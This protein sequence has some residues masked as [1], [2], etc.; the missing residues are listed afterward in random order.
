MENPFILDIDSYKRDIASV[1]QYVEQASMFLHTTTKKDLDI[2]REYVQNTIKNKTLTDIKDPKFTYLE[3][4]DTGDRIKETTTLSKYLQNAIDNE[5]IISAPL[6]TYLPLHVKESYVA[7]YL[8]NNIKLRNIAKKAQFAAEAKGD[9]TLKNIKNSEQTNRKLKNNAVSG[10][11]VSNSTPLFN[12]T[13]HATLTSTCRCTAGYGNSNNEKLMSGNRHYYSPS[14][15]INNITSIITITDLN[16]LQLVIDK[17]NL[18]IPTVDD[19]INCIKKSTDYYWHDKYNLDIITDYIVTLSPVQRAAVVYVGDLYHVMKLNSNF[20]KVFIGEISARDITVIDKPL[21]IIYQIR[22]DYVELAHQIMSKEL[23]GKGKDYRALD[24]KILND[25]TATA[26]HIENTVIKYKDFI[27]AIMVTPNVP[28]SVA[29]FPNS[30]REVALV[31]DTDSTIFTVQ[32][33]VRWYCGDI[34]FTEEADA[35]AATCIFLAS[36]AITHILAMMSANFGVDKSNLFLIAMKNEFKFSVFVPSNVAKHYFASITA[37]EGNIKADTEI[38]IKGVHLKNSN[39]P[40]PIIKAANQLME[41]IL[42]DTQQGKQIS[43]FETL[44]FVADIERYVYDSIKKG[45]VEI[46]KILNIQK[47]EAYKNPEQSNYQR[48]IFWNTTFGTKYSIMPEP[49]YGCIKVSTVLNNKKA[50]TQWLDLMEDKALSDLLRKYIVDNN[51]SNL[52]VLFIPYEVT[53]QFGIPKEI[54][55]IVDSRSIVAD[56]CKIFYIILET[57]GIYILGTKQIKLASDD[58]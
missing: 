57:L 52:D 41:K 4:Q 25:L 31:S 47:A 51:K 3:R 2:C 1:K 38:E 13:A 23:K 35:V 9:I 21:D 8:I 29:N 19:T 18:Y 34:V 15:V 22:E 48:H 26:L 16:K 32:D 45:S 14:V 55:D 56:L 28:A 5:L 12:P 53:T 17:Y 7:R 27:Q 43:I 58:Y 6:T 24:S 54:M 33:W 44:K 20:M 10:A 42:D 39:V 50:L 11:H 30:I 37:Q 49:P 36:Q 40:K 46:F